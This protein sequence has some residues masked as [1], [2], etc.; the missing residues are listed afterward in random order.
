VEYTQNRTVDI[1]TG[2]SCN[3]NCVHCV[4]SDS[5]GV[6]PDLDTAKILDLLRKFRVDCKDLVLTGG[7]VTLRA[8]APYLVEMTGTLGYRYITIQTNGRMLAYKELCERFVS[9]GTT[10]FVVAIHGSNLDIHNE[11]TRCDSFEQTVQGIKNLISLKANVAT[12]TVISRY[13]MKDLPAIAEFLIGIGI[14]KIKL[15]YPHILGNARINAEEILI[16]KT[17]VLP[18]LH[19]AIDR[20]RAG[21]ASV[22]VEAI[23]YCLMQGYEEHVVEPVSPPT[24]MWG[25]ENN[26]IQDYIQHRKNVD[27]LKRVECLACAYNDLCEGP[28]K[29]YP[30]DFG[31]DEFQP[32]ESRTGMPLA[33]EKW[34]FRP[35]GI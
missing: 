7:E 18:Y 1:K 17:E 21:R 10:G 16:R 34:E 30:G 31:W 22:M 35:S 20:C 29:E 11:I 3:N 2:Y 25:G 6:Q 4:A 13:N 19:E 8:D 32:R 33:G 15:T 23:P 5:R 27:K 28:W 26:F 14:K 12:N 24:S 9:A